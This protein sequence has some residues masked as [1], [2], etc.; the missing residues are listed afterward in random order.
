MSQPRRTRL[1]CVN[2]SRDSWQMNI[3]FFCAI[4]R[5]SK[6]RHRSHATQFP[7]TWQVPLTEIQKPN[8]QK[9]YD[10]ITSHRMTT[11]HPIRC[12]VEK[13][14]KTRRNQ[15]INQNPSKKKKTK[16]NITKDEKSSSSSKK[17]EKNHHHRWDLVITLCCV[18]FRVDFYLRLVQLLLH[19]WGD[20][21]PQ[22]KN[23]AAPAWCC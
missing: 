11:S 21:R 4:L 13:K 10:A 22:N 9:T 16:P 17:H 1:N 8:I 3:L 19:F 2:N 6:L 12:G 23:S 14:E 18:L 20:H 5:Y 7:A 15:I